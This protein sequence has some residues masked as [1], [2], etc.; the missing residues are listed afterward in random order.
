MEHYANK[1]PCG[2]QLRN[3]HA[4]GG[5]VAHQARTEVP[6]GGGAKPGMQGTVWGPPATGCLSV[7]VYPAPGYAAKRCSFA[8]PFFHFHDVDVVMIMVVAP[9][10]FKF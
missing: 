5:W 9:G 1:Q 8:D 6:K 3:I 2:G 7:F 4:V 10:N